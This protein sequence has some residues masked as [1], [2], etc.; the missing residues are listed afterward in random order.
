M[1]IKVGTHQA[2][3]H[4]SDLLRQVEKGDCVIITRRGEPIAELR[5]VT[6][7]GLHASGSLQWDLPDRNSLLEAL[8]PEAEIEKNFYT[9]D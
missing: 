6:S 4:L 8:E 7:P 9:G 1:K 2:K 3:T 5:R